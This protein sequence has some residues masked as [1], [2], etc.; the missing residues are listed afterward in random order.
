MNIVVDSLK[1]D[2]VIDLLQEA[3]NKK[4]KMVYTL[5]SKK[6]KNYDYSYTV[7]P[8]W[9]ADDMEAPLL[10]IKD[11]NLKSLS[12][13]GKKVFEELSENNKNISAT[14]FF[15]LDEC[16]SSVVSK[17][18]LVNIPDI[19]KDMVIEKEIELY[20]N[21]NMNLNNMFSLSLQLERPMNSFYYK[22]KEKM[23][24]LGLSIFH[25]SFDKEKNSWIYVSY[26]TKNNKRELYSTL[27]DYFENSDVNK[28]NN[29]K[30]EH[31]GIYKLI[32]DGFYQ[33]ANRIK[34]EKEK[35]TVDIWDTKW[36]Q[37][38]SAVLEK[39]WTS[40][41][42]ANMIYNNL[43]MLEDSIKI[44]KESGL[45]KHEFFKKW[46]DE[47]K[48]FEEK[49][50]KNFWIKE[51]KQYEEI[52]SIDKDVFYKMFPEQYRNGF[53]SYGSENS[54]FNNTIKT[55][56]SQVLDI[57]F[58]IDLKTFGSSENEILL[59]L[60]GKKEIDLNKVYSL[61]NKVVEDML[62]FST[63]DAYFSNK[64]EY[65]NRVENII[66]NFEKEDI[67]KNLEKNEKKASKIK[68]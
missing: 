16:F 8:V 56:F 35:G 50:L 30:P 23:D 57:A 2:F 64:V 66:S 20:N 34:I 5:K 55:I 15:M 7:H 9:V 54:V 38:T 19:Y 17:N 37:Y 6:N 26:I 29:Y 22:N 51:K 61:L 68:F 42:S 46:L 67:L 18:E 59:K 28:L 31:P 14:N 10:E 1:K 53:S 39:V 33:I 36:G 32:I 52:L 60:V 48:V 25:M 24:L 62:N 47:N 49:T 21:I 63:M 65:L 58:N 41:W 13:F 12:R 44:M 3:S 4:Y 45:E 43:N 11:F 27:L 40:Y